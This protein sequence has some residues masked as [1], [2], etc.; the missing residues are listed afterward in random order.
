MLFN[1]LVNTRNQNPESRDKKPVPKTVKRSVVIYGAGGFGREV[2]SLM[3]ALPE[4]EVVAFYD[5]GIGKGNHRNKIPVAGGMETLLQQ[6]QPLDVILGIGDPMIRTRLAERLKESQHRFPVIVHP[7]AIL[8]D[9]TTITLGD[10][11]IITA[12]VIL[13]NDIHLGR[14]VLLNLN[15]TVGH[16]VA[17]G[18]CSS[19]MPGANIA[20]GVTIGKSV[21]IGSGANVLN[22]ITIGDGARIGSGAVVTK[23]VE[24]GTTVVGVP[25]QPNLT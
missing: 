15:V 3:R 9:E 5:D 7:R 13:T 20:G 8:Q 18:D 11:T 17:I 6:E 25:A 16:D 19:V 21:L 24:P 23:N 22:G 12:G 4:W 10:G 1:K 14:H 2:L